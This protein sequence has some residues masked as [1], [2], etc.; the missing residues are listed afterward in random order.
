[1]LPHEKSDLL[2]AIAR[3]LKDQ[4]AQT[5]HDHKGETVGWTLEDPSDTADYVLA[6]VLDGIEAII[7]VMPAE[8]KD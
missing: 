2:K 7:E 8:L 1:M 4:A 3:V 6:A 5:V